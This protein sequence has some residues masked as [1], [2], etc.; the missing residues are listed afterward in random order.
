MT[1]RDQSSES[2]QASLRK[3]QKSK[4]INTSST[5]QKNSSIA[6]T[7]SE[8][9]NFDFSAP[10]DFYTTS[11]CSSV[12][13]LGLQDLQNLESL[14]LKRQEQLE[15]EEKEESRSKTSRQS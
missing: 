7:P 14:I 8:S 3:S 11:V 2:S 6:E 4:L 15:H 5:E 12:E 1:E 13:R 10:K 9:Q